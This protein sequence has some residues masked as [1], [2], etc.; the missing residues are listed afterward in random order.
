MND[1]FDISTLELNNTNYID[2]L[3]GLIFNSNFCLF[4][5]DLY[6]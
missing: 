4:G 1:L 5:K 3:F 2:F 6:I